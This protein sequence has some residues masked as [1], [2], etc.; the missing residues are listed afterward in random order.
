MITCQR[1][2]V[3]TVAH[4]NCLKFDMRWVPQSPFQSQK[5]IL[6]E[7]SIIMAETPKDF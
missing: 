4:V 6:H 5:N 3:A 7:I 1:F 2:V